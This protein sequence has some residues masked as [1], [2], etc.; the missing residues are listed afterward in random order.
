[1]AEDTPAK[2]GSGT[3]ASETGE[4]GVRSIKFSDSATDYDGTPR[5]GF[6]TKGKFR[7]HIAS[8]LLGTLEDS[9]VPTYFLRPGGADSMLV[10][11]TKPFPLDVTCYNA[12]SGSFMNRMKLAEGEV[13]PFTVVE[14]KLVGSTGNTIKTVTEGDVKTIQARA[15]MTNTAVDEFLF[16]KGYVLAEMKLRF[17]RDHQG[18]ILVSTDISPDTCRIWDR[19]EH[20]KVDRDGFRKDIGEDEATYRKIAKT[21][22]D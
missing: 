9:D 13:L 14:F 7:N 10:K 16:S 4:S 8:I 3:S 12:A 15:L 6:E 18:N 11:A 22:T 5:A 19:A 17:G 1:M 20:E 21:L 2:P